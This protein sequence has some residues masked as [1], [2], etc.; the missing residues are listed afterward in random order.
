MR[1]MYCSAVLAAKIV[2]EGDRG[3]RFVSTD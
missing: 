1:W 3:Q 2:W